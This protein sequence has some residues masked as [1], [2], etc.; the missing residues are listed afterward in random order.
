M[1]VELGNQEG[2]IDARDIIRDTIGRDN[3]GRTDEGETGNGG[4]AAL[5]DRSILFTGAY[6]SEA[7][8]GGQ[9]TLHEVVNPLYVEINQAT[10]NNYE[11][12]LASQITNIGML[13]NR[14][15]PTPGVNLM[16]Y[17]LQSNNQNYSYMRELITI[18]GKPTYAE[19]NESVIVRYAADRRKIHD[20]LTGGQE[21]SEEEKKA[22]ASKAFAITTMLM[23][24]NMELTNIAIG[25]EVTKSRALRGQDFTEGIHVRADEERTRLQNMIASVRNVVGMFQPYNI[26]TGIHDLV[27]PDQ[28]NYD[29]AGRLLADLQAYLND[30]AIPNRDNVKAYLKYVIGVDID[31]IDTTH[32][33]PG[34]TQI[35]ARMQTTTDN[36]GN[37]IPAYAPPDRGDLIQR[38][39]AM[40]HAREDFLLACGVDAANIRPMEEFIHYF[41]GRTMFPGFDEARQPAAMQIRFY[42]DVMSEYSRLTAG[43][44][45]MTEEAR[46]YWLRYARTNVLTREVQEY[47]T[48]ILGQEAR[49]NTLEI[50]RSGHEQY[51]GTNK[52]EIVRKRTER[53]TTEKTKLEGKRTALEEYKTAQRTVS[54]LNQR[55]ADELSIA[56]DDVMK[57][58][59]EA[60]AEEEAKLDPAITTS[61][62][63]L[64]LDLQNTIRGKL[65][66]QRTAINATAEKIAL[67]PATGGKGASAVKYDAGDIARSNDE[68][69]S[70]SYQSELEMRTQA[71]SEVNARIKELK[72]FRK[73]YRQALRERQSKI[74]LAGETFIGELTV[75]QEDWSALHL[76]PPHGLALTPAQIKDESI[77]DLVER[78]TP[79]PPTGIALLD[80]LTTEEQRREVILKAKARQKAEDEQAVTGQ[81]TLN[82]A[83]LRNELITTHPPTISRDELLVGSPQEL[84]Q[85]A[86]VGPYNWDAK[87]RPLV[88]ARTHLTGAALDRAVRTEILMHITS[89]KQAMVVDGE[90]WY[91]LYITEKTDYLDGEIKAVPEAVDAQAGLKKVALHAL[92]NNHDVYAE[93]NYLAGRFT[94]ARN[95]NAQVERERF[96]DNTPSATLI[97]S[98]EFA[99]YTQREQELIRDDHVLPAYFNII[100]NIYADAPA[101]ARRPEILNAIYQSINEQTL[102]N[103]LNTYIMTPHGGVMGGTPDLNTVLTELRARTAPGMHA[104]Q[105]ISPENFR[106]FYAE[107]V[108]TITRRAIAA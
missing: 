26:S 14:P 74:Q 107:L 102:A 70:K 62:Q 64:L 48:E 15:S 99:N 55:A 85:K 87:Y 38:N 77:G 104:V 36:F 96:F 39:A 5:L 52:D 65:E 71:V 42:Q 88:A 92:E 37:V 76:T 13:V 66:T 54:E 63:Y 17:V 82:Q 108:Q 18:L 89:A 49:S 58:I 6:T 7:I 68:A 35:E 46:L 33:I 45:G 95:P 28:L 43:L 41:E 47:I 93:A 73:I 31:A 83:R 29:S 30:P 79:P 90:R 22:R 19:N 97:A 20:F 103:L 4:P 105:T 69:I 44:A 27:I 80:G 106:R 101:E 94:L 91:R 23:E 16:D 98:P 100:R 3:A 81:P 60:I 32:T 24:Q 51:T 75:I 86:I 53:L 21:G 84:Y 61:A 10:F 57:G 40:Q 59:A 1:A 2:A 67:A 56:D 78:I 50:L 72:E 8:G 34:T 9:E 11:A 25:V 12:F